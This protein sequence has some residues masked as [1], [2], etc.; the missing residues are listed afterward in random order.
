MEEEKTKLVPALPEEGL[1][2]G[3]VGPDLNSYP[4]KMEA[5]VV[6]TE[7]EEEERE[8]NNMKDSLVFP[9]YPSLWL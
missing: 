5:L 7:S 8:S 9:V 6:D 1:N 4:I 3:T 2:S